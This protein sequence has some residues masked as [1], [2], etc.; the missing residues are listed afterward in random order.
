METILLAGGTGLIGKRLS[1]LLQQ[2]GYEVV[3][4]SRKQNLQ[5]TYPAYQWD[6]DKGIIDEEAIRKADCVINL[7]GAGIADKRW[8]KSR[9]QVIMDSRV[10]GTELLQKYFLTVKAPKVM[11]S[12]AAI[13]YYGERGQN[14]IQENSGA[15]TNGFLV[16]SCMAWENAIDALNLAITSRSVVIRV[17]IVLSTLGGAFEKMLLP[18]KVRTGSYFGD[19]SAIY[20]WIHIDD[21]CGIF[22]AAI[23][24]ESMSGVYNGVA[25]KPVSNKTLTEATGKA[26]GT[27]NLILPAP[28][29]AL[30]LAMGEMADVVLTS[31]N[32]SAQKIMESG[33]EF[34]F[35]EIEGAAR[36]LLE[37]RI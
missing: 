21:I 24:N 12:S 30:R 18:F 17:G 15:G 33:Y 20:S 27:T 4:L 7:A 22:I 19:G 35:S 29:F 13:G 2:K 1:L 5:A 3:H 36:D 37:R 25:P 23:E 16:E 14:L 31:A 28:S 6:L 11:I 34:Q 8:T 32:V 26:L 9:K 10:K